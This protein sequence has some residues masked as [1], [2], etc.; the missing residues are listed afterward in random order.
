LFFKDYIETKVVYHVAP[1]NK[2]EEIL[3][4][5]LIVDKECNQKYRKFN[6]YFD[7]LKPNYIP[8][9]VT[10]SRAIYGSINFKDDHSWHSHSAIL[11]L[12]IDEDKC[13]VANE[14]LANIIYEPFIL[15]KTSL[16]KSAD[17]FIKLHGEEYV[18]NYWKN[19]ISFKENLR[20]RKDCIKEFDAEV[21]IIHD[22]SPRDIRIVKL[23]TDHRLMD[24]DELNKTFM[25]FNK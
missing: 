19:S 2:L 24:V 18:M 12:K 10:R 7:N 5:G 6:H 1:I 16:F 17:S 21:L 23:S 11:S 8:G 25:T 22:I 3:E 4:K 13:W 14:N 9:W 20:F 15:R